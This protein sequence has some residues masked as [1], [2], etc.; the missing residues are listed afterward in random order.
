M[1]SNRPNPVVF[2]IP[3]NLCSYQQIQATYNELN[4]GLIEDNGWSQLKPYRQKHFVRK[5]SDTIIQTLEIKRT[6]L[7]MGGGWVIAAC[8]SLRNWLIFNSKWTV[9]TQNSAT[10]SGLYSNT[11]RWNYA[12]QRPLSIFWMTIFVSFCCVFLSTEQERP[13]HAMHW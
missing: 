7:E 4:P 1:S 3:I 9:L 11:C 10:V 8:F 13:R 2:Q 6:R 12:C 5:Y